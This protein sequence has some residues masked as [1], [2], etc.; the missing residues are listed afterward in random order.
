MLFVAV[1]LHIC[2]C[3]FI[4]VFVFVYLQFVLG[5]STSLAAMPFGVLAD[6]LEEEEV[7]QSIVEIAGGTIASGVGTVM[8]NIFEGKKVKE[9]VASGILVGGMIL[10]KTEKD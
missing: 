5:A 9:N 6:N 2:V 7:R 8:Q 3:Y 10:N 4:F 1:Y